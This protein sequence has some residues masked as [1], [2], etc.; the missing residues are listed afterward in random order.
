VNGTDAAYKTLQ[1]CITERK[2]KCIWDQVVN[3][4]V[5][6]PVELNAS[7]NGRKVN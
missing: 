5:D 2:G 7:S 4:R 1:Q 3:E 6:K